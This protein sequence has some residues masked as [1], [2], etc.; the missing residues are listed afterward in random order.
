[1]RYLDIGKGEP[2]LL[3]HGLSSKKESWFPQMEISDQYRLIIPD[4]RGHGESD[5]EDGITLYN[6][7]K[8]II[9]LIHKLNIDS[10]HICGL[11]L[12]G[13]VAQEILK[14]ESSIVKSIILANTVSV[15]PSYIVSN[16]VRKAETVLNTV[17]DYEYIRGIAKAGI[18]DKENDELLTRAIDSFR[19]NRN[20]Y[21]D[22]AKSGIGVNYLPMLMT[23]IVP[24]LIIGATH[25]EVTPLINAYTTYFYAKNAKLKVINSCGHLSNIEK[26]EEFNSI[27]LDFLKN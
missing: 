17:S 20:T 23:D 1:M 24:K 13:I 6:F 2:L 9:E 26:S 22:A 18:Y 16:I 7:A 11:S 19:I 14:Q 5:V 27:L 12:G 15:M 3:I 21:M 4:L 25:D 8:D 10:I